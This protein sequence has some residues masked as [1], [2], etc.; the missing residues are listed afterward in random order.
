MQ[1]CF[2]AADQRLITASKDKTAKVWDA[3]MKQ[4][5]RILARDLPTGCRVVFDSTGERILLGL[6]DGKIRSWSIKSGQEGSPSATDTVSPTATDQDFSP[7][8]VRVV[9]VDGV[10]VIGKRPENTSEIVSRSVYEDPLRDQRWHTEE[11]QIAEKAKDA[12]ATR[13]HQAEELTCQARIALKSNRFDEAYGYFLAAAV[14]KPRATA[15]R[16]PE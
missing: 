15:I 13:F 16:W 14:S 10:L 6:P 4:E 8:R 5:A 11:R 12:F 1:L 7:D 3:R 2:D 9:W